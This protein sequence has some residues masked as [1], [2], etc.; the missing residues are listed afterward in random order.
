MTT[1][2]RRL[3]LHPSALSDAEYTLFTA[4]LADL[5]E[6]GSGVD[7]TAREARAWIRGRYQS[8]GGAVLDEILRLFPATLTGGAFFA[9]LRL[10][11]HVQAGR[12]C[13]S[14]LGVC[15]SLAANFQLPATDVSIDDIQPIPPHP[16]SIPRSSYAPPSK[17]TVALLAVVCVELYVGFLL[18]S[19]LTSKSPS[20]PPCVLGVHVRSCAPPP[21]PSHPL[22]RAST[23][24]SRSPSP[25]LIPFPNS[26]P[27]QNAHA[28]TQPHPHTKNNP[29]RTHH[30]PKPPLPPRR[31]SLSSTSLPLPDASSPTPRTA[32]PTRST[33]SPIVPPLPPPVPVSPFDA[34]A[35]V[36][37][38]PPTPSSASASPFD[39]AP[40]MM[41]RKG[42]PPVHPQRRAS[43]EVPSSSSH[44]HA[45]SSSVRAFTI[46]GW[47]W[48][49]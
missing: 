46:L 32:P 25:P 11:L 49:W 37:V 21:P 5:A 12:A 28:D 26:S 45:H 16:R 18:T 20:P 33:F 3:S 4:S 7:V 1:T 13:R 19:Q 9:L 41:S 29:F 15:T 44:S 48:N 8:L 31:A 27:T 40:T 23:Q 10:V 47:E 2:P 30:P 39:G 24:T 22:R 38:M 36:Q 6:T 17:T 34:H 35:Q 14:E 42:P 43:V